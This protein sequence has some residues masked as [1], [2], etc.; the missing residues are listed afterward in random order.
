MSI[1]ILFDI[2]TTSDVTELIKLRIF[3]SNANFDLQIR[4]NANLQ[5]CHFTLG[6]VDRHK[7][8]HCLPRWFL[9]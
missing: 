1:N 5:A 2:V 8:T 3:S 9:V 7:L 6:P 4:S